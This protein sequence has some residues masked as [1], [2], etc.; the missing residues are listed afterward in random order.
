MHHTVT[1]IAS[2][3]RLLVIGGRGSPTQPNSSIF[4]L[5]FNQPQSSR[6]LWSKIVLH[7]ESSQMEP[8]WRHT[9]SCINFYGG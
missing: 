7:P 3:T 6:P 2:G 1:A 9:A 5:K 8:C 4:L